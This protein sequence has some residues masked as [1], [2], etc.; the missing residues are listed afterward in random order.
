M[1]GGTRNRATAVLFRRR[2]VQCGQR[3][4]D[5]HSVDALAGGD[6]RTKMRLTS[7]ST[8]S[9]PEA[10]GRIVVP[11]RA[12]FDVAIE[13]CGAF[14]AAMPFDHAIRF[15]RPR[16]RGRKAAPQ[17]VAGDPGRIDPDGPTPSLHH[18][19]DHDPRVPRC[20]DRLAA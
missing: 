4:V 7:T 16:G 3:S 1:S 18:E 14:P 5:I 10:N 15:L 2:Y 17:T 19:R 12:V 13:H 6:R 9:E 8:R 20:A 11:A